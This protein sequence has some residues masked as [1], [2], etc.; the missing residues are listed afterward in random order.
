[1]TAYHP[2]KLPDYPQL[3]LL[4]ISNLTL[5][6][7]SFNDDYSADNTLTSSIDTEIYAADAIYLFLGLR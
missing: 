2:T 6:I 1:M 5:I 3:R 7:S 4:L